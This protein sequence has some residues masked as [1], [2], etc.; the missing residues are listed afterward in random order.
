MVYDFKKGYRMASQLPEPINIEYL[1][2]LN[3]PTYAA[4]NVAHTVNALIHYLKEHE[5]A[6]Q[7]LEKKTSEVQTLEKQYKS[8]DS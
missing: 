1:R 6:L 8:S 2:G 5:S 7:Q 4:A 3:P